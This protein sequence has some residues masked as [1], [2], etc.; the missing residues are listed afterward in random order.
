MK[1]CISS[2]HGKYIRGASG[3]P[4][5]PPFCDEVDEARKIVETSATELRKLGVEVLTFHD[6]TSHDQS[7]N[8]ST[9]VAWHN[10]QSRDLDV[11]VHLNCYD[12]S[13]HGVEVL[14]VSQ[15]ELAAKISTAI[16]KIG[17]TNRGAKKR[18]DLA[19]LNGTDEPAVLLEVLFCDNRGDCD[20]Y[21]SHFA[22]VC[23]AIAESLSGQ[24]VQPGPT[25][26]QPPQPEPAPEP[27]PQPVGHPMLSEGSEGPAVV[28]LQ[29]VL[30]LPTDG[31][32]GNITAT[33]VEG[34]QKAC[35]LSPDAIVG[36]MTWDAVDELERRLVDGDERLADASPI[37]EYEWP[38][39]GISPPGYITGMSLCYAITAQDFEK[40]AAYAGTMAK[41]LGS[42]DVDALKWYES[43]LKA[44]GCKL[45]TAADRLRSLFVLMIGL[46]MRESSGRYCEGR[47]LSAGSS[48]TQSDTCEA[49]LMQTSW[50]IRSADAS[51]PGLLTEYWNN[52]NGF[53]QEF[54]ENV[55]P[56]A[57]NLDVAGTGEGARYQWLAK[58][59]PAFAVMTSGVGLRKR[60]DHWG[61]IKRK[62][63]T[64]NKD[65]WA[66]LKQIDD[67]LASIA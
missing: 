66:L 51:L 46:S 19:F 35:G 29:T 38:D 1:I 37:D 25:P 3:P 12:G 10:K 53:R 8:L 40:A 67:T 56:T 63:V 11:S 45:D 13:A 20:R 65:A 28:E 32:F 62:E 21:R 34:F 24:Q 64:I 6:N 41:G 15:Q 49:G 22:D 23:R 36:P 5:I 52:P 47:D 17:F 27:P 39:R 14:Y 59:C 26:P 43:D 7:T 31:D 61:P 54:A 4:P 44:K 60:K 48:S 18:T 16:A 30:G 33:Q 42:S 2:G 9:I 55:D 57:E 58:F 50:N